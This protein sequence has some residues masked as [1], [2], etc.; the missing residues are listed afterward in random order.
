MT[1]SAIVRL[2]CIAIAACSATGA[3]AYTG[4]NLAHNAKLT[5]AQ[6]TAIAEKARAGV[7][8]DR[9]LERENGGLRYSFDVKAKGHTYEVGVDAMTGKV[10]ENRAEP[11]NP[12]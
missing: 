3:F 9:E 6:A 8:T 12:D 4:E 2:A 1:R 10:L 11:K 5:M 7:I